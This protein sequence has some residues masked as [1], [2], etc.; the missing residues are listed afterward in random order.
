[1]KSLVITVMKQGG[2]GII[3]RGCIH[4]TGVGI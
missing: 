3:V 4:S 2:G 1:M